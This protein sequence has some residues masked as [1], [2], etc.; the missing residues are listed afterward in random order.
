MKKESKDIYDINVNK[1]ALSVQGYYELSICQILIVQN[2]SGM[3]SSRQQ[4]MQI[5]RDLSKIPE[6]SIQPE[7]SSTNL[8][9]DL[10]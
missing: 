7:A 5:R 4:P 9:V 1:K 10:L 8:I 2:A 3:S 6:K